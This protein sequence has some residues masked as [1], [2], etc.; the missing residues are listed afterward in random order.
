MILV[1][2]NQIVRKFEKTLKLLIEPQCKMEFLTMR[3]N[4]IKILR[5]GLK[6]AQIMQTNALLGAVGV[7]VSMA[8][9][10]AQ[11]TPISHFPYAHFYS[12]LTSN[13][14]KPQVFASSQMATRL[15]YSGSPL[16]FTSS[17]EM[18][19]AGCSTLAHTN[20]P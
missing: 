12:S 6:K 1:N 8:E 19:I 4:A 20:S 11:Q 15:F 10:L 18:Q 13:R 14:L 16:Y 7:N 5:N 9:F 3:L 2:N 17:V